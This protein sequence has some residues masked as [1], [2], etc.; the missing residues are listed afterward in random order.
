MTLMQIT[1]IQ[2]AL[3]QEGLDGWLFFDHHRRDPLAYR[4]L[5]I[6]AEIEA[7]RR[8]YYFVP[9]EGEPRKLVHQIEKGA[10]DSLPGQKQVYSNWVD[11]RNRLTALL[12]SAKRIAMQYSP[13]CSIPYVSLVDAGTM[14]LVRATGVEVA[15]SANLVQ[16]FEAKWSFDQLE[17]HLEAGRRVDEIRRK[18]FDLIGERLRCSNPVNEYEVQQF[19]RHQFA[20]SGL[21]TDHGP[22]VG[23]NANASDPHYE[24]TRD[25]KSYIQ[26]GDFVLI[27]L[28]AKL[29]APGAVYYD[30]TWTGYCGEQIPELI[31][32]VF[33]IVKTARHRASDF[34]I[35]KAR[36]HQAFA[37]FEVD[38]VCREYITAQGYGSNFFHRTG[39]SIGTEVHGT[40]ANMDNLESHD[41]RRVIANTCFSVE[42][43]IYLAEF[44]VR[45][46]V[47]VFV[48]EGDARV[49]GEEQEQL[50]RI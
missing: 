33:D 48:S 36:A 32:N 44:G 39:H 40:G 12:G 27:D 46:E 1:A 17:M 49:T 41:E 43:G 5:S 18:A 3:R 25:R 9:T 10:L 6:P 30:V 31:Q 42:P 29:A 2:D 26:K 47:N 35:Q 14:E 16:E 34:A 28:W 20:Q 50:I 37:G 8:W 19:V 22:I 7:T 11:Q 24:P 45:S 38:D 13:N 15:T 23:V 4:I 21:E